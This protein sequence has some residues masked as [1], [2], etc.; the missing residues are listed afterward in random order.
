MNK[1]GIIYRVT[2]LLNNKIY[3]GQTS[4]RFELRKR[5]HIYDSKHKKTYFHE[6]LKKYSKEQFIWEIIETVDQ[7]LLNEREIYYIN[8]YDSTAPNKGYNLTKG[9]G[10]IRR[11]F[12]SEETKQ[13][14][15]LSRMGKYLGKDNPNYGRHLSKEAKDKIRLSHNWKGKKQTDESR[16]KT[17][18]SKGGRYF[19]IKLNDT[20]LEEFFSIRECAKK[21]N[22]DNSY[23]AKCLKTNRSCKGYTFEYTK[24][25]NIK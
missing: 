15:A 12:H 14:I 23:L 8:L 11:F 21:Y 16:M 17:T 22:L 10:G 7:D 5:K 4:M 3:I 25:I 18:A 9:G 24:L 20:I 6:A 13:K 2:N 1:T 19:V